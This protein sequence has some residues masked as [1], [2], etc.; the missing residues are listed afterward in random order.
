MSAQ[1][2][3]DNSETLC[4]SEQTIFFDEYYISLV[5]SFLHGRIGALG[6]TN[7]RPTEDRFT[8]TRAELEIKMA[9]LLGGRAAEQIIF[10]HQSTG[11]QV[12]LPKLRI[13]LA[14]W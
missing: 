4:V 12:I 13:S 8:M 5:G 11:P 2:V 7:Q 6:Y 9:V 3:D 1:V 10:K 14:V